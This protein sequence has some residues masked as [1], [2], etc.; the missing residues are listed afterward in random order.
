MK[1]KGL[2]PTLHHAETHPAYLPLER[3][4]DS[5]A[6]AKTIGEQISVYKQQNPSE[7]IHDKL[8]DQLILHVRNVPGPKAED[9]SWSPAQRIVWRRGQRRLAG[10]LA[11]LTDE[12][13]LRIIDDRSVGPVHA[14]A[15]VNAGRWVVDCPS[16]NCNSAQ[17]ASYGDRR[18]FCCDCAMEE[19]GGKWAKVLWPDN[20]LEVENWLSNRIDA[21]KHWNPGETGE[22]IA[23]QDAFAMGQFIQPKPQ[24][25][26]PSTFSKTAEMLIDGE[27]RIFP[28]LHFGTPE[29]DE[30]QKA[31]EN[32]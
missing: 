4:P 12:E 1:V 3:G 16:P 27:K 2:A 10:T 11:P 24:K 26:D 31:A 22:D 17:M 7:T 9:A 19:L 8:V 14:Y 28:V 21:V 20:H 13:K 23:R 30:S 5:I 15:R 32:G 18:F 25:V 6:K 29:W